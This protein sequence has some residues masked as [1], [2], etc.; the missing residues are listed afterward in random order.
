M[1]KLTRQKKREFKIIVLKEC[2]EF[3]NRRPTSEVLE[4]EAI[5]DMQQGLKNWIAALE[6]KR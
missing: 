2:L 4:T 5:E 1:K 6:K 3:M